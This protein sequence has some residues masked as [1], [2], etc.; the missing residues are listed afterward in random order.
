[1]MSAIRRSI[2][3]SLDL[4]MENPKFSG[5]FIRHY[6]APEIIRSAAPFTIKPEGQWL[7]IMDGKQLKAKPQNV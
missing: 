7:H 3:I 5:G 4:H 1:M 6:E 2:D